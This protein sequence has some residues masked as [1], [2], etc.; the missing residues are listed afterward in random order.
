M[1]NEIK[2]LEAGDRVPLHTLMRAAPELEG[3]NENHQRYITEREHPYDGE[4]GDKLFADDNSNQVYGC[5]LG[6]VAM[7]CGI[8]YN[9]KLAAEE[10]RGK[11]YGSLDS[12]WFASRLGITT[13]LAKRI[14]RRHQDGMKMVD[15][16]DWLESNY[17]SVMVTIE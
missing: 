15:I 14:D 2:W 4:A 1:T 12:G 10:D 9:M 17:P 6:G 13:D 8:V 7:A 11:L 16:A 3:F 5:A